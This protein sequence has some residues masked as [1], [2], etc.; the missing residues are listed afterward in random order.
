[1]IIALTVYAFANYEYVMSFVLRYR[2]VQQLKLKIFRKTHV[3]SVTEHQTLLAP[4]RFGVC[5]ETTV[6][7]IL[8]ACKQL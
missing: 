3:N 8:P 6:V 5:E 7:Q 4:Q 1:M 2:R